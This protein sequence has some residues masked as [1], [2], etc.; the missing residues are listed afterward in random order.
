MIRR[1]TL[2]ER[3]MEEKTSVLLSSR[4]LHRRRQAWSYKL[5]NQRDARNAREMLLNFYMMKSGL[6]RNSISKLSHR[7]KTFW[8]EENYAQLHRET[9]GEEPEIYRNIKT[10]N[11]LINKYKEI[12]K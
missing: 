11:N 8:K 6:C 7:A 2:T 12:F 5:T 9:G 4:K 3:L 1:R 10:M